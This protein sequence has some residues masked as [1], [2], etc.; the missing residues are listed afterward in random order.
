ML[1]PVGRDG[2]TVHAVAVS[3]E[4]VATKD[5]IADPTTPDTLFGVYAITGSNGVEGEAETDKE[6]ATTTVTVT[7]S[8]PALFVAVTTKFEE[9]NVVVGVP[10]N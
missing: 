10:E 4:L 6:S 8:L 1:I 3:P 2:L 5:V 9:V 7:E